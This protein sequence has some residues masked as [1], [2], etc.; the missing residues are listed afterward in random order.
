MVELVRIASSH[1]VGYG[2]KYRAIR[3]GIR[4]GTVMKREDWTVRGTRVQWEASDASGKYI[5][6]FDTR[7]LA[8]A[9]LG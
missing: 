6:S 1:K 8:I 5:S 4:I 7:K 9:A 3:D 2:S